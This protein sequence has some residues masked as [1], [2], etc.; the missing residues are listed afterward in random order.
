MILYDFRCTEGHRFE[1]GIASMH[2]SNPE[3]PGCGAATNRVPSRVQIGGVADAGPSREQMPRSWRG[4]GN[5]HPDAVAHWRSTIEKREKLEEK[6]PELAGDRRPVL[7]HEGIFQGR[8]LRAGDDIP[9]SIRAA[10]KAES[11]AAQAQAAAAPSAAA[12]P[13]KSAKSAS[14]H[15]HSHSHST[16]GR[17]TA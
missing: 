10:R 5:G 14:G 11:D 3:C 7:A 12:P 8:P 15:S 16:T 4:V 1:A 13:A 17:K 9:A 6:H 2:A